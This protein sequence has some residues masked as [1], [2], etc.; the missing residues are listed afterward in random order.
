MSDA[1]KAWHEY[2]DEYW[3]LYTQ[4]FAQSLQA[5]GLFS[6]FVTNPCVTGAYAE[7]CVWSLTRSMLGHRFRLSTGAVIRPCD[8]GRGLSSVMQCDLIVWDPSEMPAIF[9]SS[10]FALVPLFA[11]RAII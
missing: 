2:R 9:E 8:R 6:S 1:R 5:N 11:T 4:A 7:S 10:E 3:D